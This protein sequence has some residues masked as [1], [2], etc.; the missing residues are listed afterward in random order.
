MAQLYRDQFA[1]YFN[2]ATTTGNSA[3]P[4]WKLVD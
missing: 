1:H 3:N 2:T 4:T